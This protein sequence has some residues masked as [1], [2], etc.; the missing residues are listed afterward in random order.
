MENSNEKIKYFLYARKSSESEDR[1][2]ASIDS[3]IDVLTDV[4][5][6]EKLDIVEILSESKSAK[7]PGRPIFNKMIERLGKG[8][9][10]GIICWKLDRLAR[11]PVDGGSIS[12]M[13]QNGVISHIK[14]YER[15]YFPTDNVLMMSVEFG[16]ANQF[17][18]DLITNTKRG[19]RSKAEKGWMPGSAPMGYLNNQ[20]KPKGEKDIIKDPE[21]F[22]LVRKMWDMLLTGN[23]STKK[24]AE[25]IESWGLKSKRFSKACNQIKIYKVFCNPFYYGYFK[26]GGE[27]YKGKHDPM[28]T[29]DEFNRAQIILGNK[30]KTHAPHNFA[31]TG[32]IR[33]GEC[34]SMITAEDKIKRQKNGNIHFYTY[35]HCTKRKHTKCSQGCI[36]K[37][38][39]EEQII[40]VLEKIEIPEEFYEW[41]IAGLRT[42]SGKEIIDRN[43][44]IENQK[45]EYDACVKKID[46]LIE[47]R[48][49][50]ELSQEEFMDRKLDLMRE[51]ERIKELLNDSDGR[52]NKWLEKAEATF[53][54]AKNARKEF[55]EGLLDKKREILS[56]LGSNLILKDNLLSISIEEPLLLVEKAAEEVR[57]IHRGLEPVQS[58]EI[59]LNLGEI[60]SKNAILG[61]QGDSNSL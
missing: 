49:N 36:T 26:Y 54:F 28:I 51:K 32:L 19:L 2:V 38:D 1:Q 39:L 29:E 8:D 50:N 61:G 47:M 4:A 41:A 14:T 42:D 58:G 35:Y 16:M 45:K 53:K 9:A 7:A 23:Y 60:Y 43:K 56:L 44:I 5:K 40:I 48:M 46:G 55:G 12:W 24:I 13:L 11:N 31:F 33:C 15:S 52:I 18:R 37:N 17:V 34:G 57:A 30:S 6:K 3:Q 25:T 22:Y 21:R 59:E 27:I 20:F 10:K